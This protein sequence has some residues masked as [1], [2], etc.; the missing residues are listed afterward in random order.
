LRDVGVTVMVPGTFPS[1]GSTVAPRRDATFQSPAGPSTLSF[2]GMMSDRPSGQSL[3]A[4]Q[5]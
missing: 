1:A 2:S 3:G 4:F 5:S